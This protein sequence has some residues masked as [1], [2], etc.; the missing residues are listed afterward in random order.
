MPN[1]RFTIST[2]PEVQSA[3]R[4]HA[5]AA[6]LDVSAYMIAAAA[7]Q[8]AAD[9]AASALFAPLDTEN[10]TAMEQSAAL[11]I[12]DAPAFEDL[13]AEEQVLVRKVVSSALGS[14]LGS[15]SADVA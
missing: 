13:S 5:D 3:I 9:D 7:A 15:D 2:D 8:M 12:P 6:G 11:G 14:A 4:V 1:T 10:T